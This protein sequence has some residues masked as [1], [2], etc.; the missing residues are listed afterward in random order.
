METQRFNSTFQGECVVLINPEEGQQP[1]SSPQQVCIS[2]TLPCPKPVPLPS[3]LQ[4]NTRSS[5][6]A[7]APPRKER[8]SPHAHAPPRKDRLRRWVEHGNVSRCH[9]VRVPSISHSCMYRTRTRIFS[10]S[11]SFVSRRLIAS[12]THRFPPKL[13]C[14]CTTTSSTYPHKPTLTHHHHMCTQSF[15]DISVLLKRPETV[16]IRVSSLKVGHWARLV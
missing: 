14:P 16:T 3:H 11:A 4:H 5:P 13:I 6:H 2:A 12:A 1:L 15:G 7:H 10:D 9:Y 8:R